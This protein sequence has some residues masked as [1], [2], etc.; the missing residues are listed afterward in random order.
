MSKQ[1]HISRFSWLYVYVY[2]SGVKT[3]PY[4]EFFL[5]DAC[6]DHVYNMGWGGVGVCVLTFM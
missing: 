3:G 5:D 6:V 1:T 4:F 2:S